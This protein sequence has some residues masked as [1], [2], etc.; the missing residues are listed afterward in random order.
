MTSTELR[1]LVAEWAAARA[2][3]DAIRRG[4]ADSSISPNT[5]RRLE[6][7]KRIIAAEAAMRAIATGA[8]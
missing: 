2:E 8:P 1:A 3:A 6:N 7:V 5:P 4:I